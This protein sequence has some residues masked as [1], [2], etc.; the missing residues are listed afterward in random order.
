MEI[1][2]IPIRLATIDDL[3]DIQS[4]ARAAYAKYVERI[5]QEPAPMIADFANQI[6][7]GHVWTAFCGS[8]FSGYVVFYPEA[9][10]MHLEN[11]AVVPAHLGKGIG[12]RL[13]KYVE[14]TAHKQGLNAVELYTNEAMTENLSMYPKLGYFETDRKQQDGFHRVFF[15][16]LV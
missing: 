13:I 8:S 1:T 11:V 9:D 4:C 15:R 16:K 2:A 7:L 3:P 12:K 14:H 6:E 5:G 10:H